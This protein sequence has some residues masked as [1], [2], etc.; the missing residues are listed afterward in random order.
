MSDRL[1]PRREVGLVAIAL[2]VVAHACIGLA[3]AALWVPPELLSSVKRRE[4]VPTDVDVLDEAPPDESI[5]DVAEKDEEAPQ[6]PQGG[7]E[8]PAE[9]QAE[10]A[11]PIAIAPPRA[12]EPKAP[13]PIEPTAPTARP[14]SPAASASTT[15]TASGAA[16]SSSA[17]GEPD[18]G[19][20][21]KRPE[22]PSVMARFT[23]DLADWSSGVPAWQTA[24]VGDAG[25]II[26]TLAVGD[27]GKIDKT[28][29]PF[30]GEADK[31]PAA[32]VESVKR[33]KSALV[34]KMGSR[35]LI[36]KLKVGAVVSDVEAPEGETLKL[37][38]DHY[39]PK[40]KKGGSTFVLGSGRRVSFSVEVL[41]TRALTDTP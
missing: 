18:G 6:G 31:L 34:T 29:D 36:V 12:P 11:K 30:G 14:T 15:A 22:L 8:R 19:G 17:P 26:V 32:L 35:N 37:S 5:A 41:E 39:D 4:V 20:G 33:T 40:T 27:D 10:P 28:H 13:T 7:A 3:L 1:S 9:K 21:V 38:F 25:S 16:P 2:S 24:P 23:H